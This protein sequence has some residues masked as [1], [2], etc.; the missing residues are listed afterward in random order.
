MMVLPSALHLW[1][2]NTIN[3]IIKIHCPYKTL[4]FVGTVER[5]H[6]KYIED[7]HCQSLNSQ[8]TISAENNF[9]DYSGFPKND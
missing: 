2:M 7:E 8:K 5:C 1:Q 3:Q 6:R 9:A 4:I